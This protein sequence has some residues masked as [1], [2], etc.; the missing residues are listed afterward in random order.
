MTG[1]SER[2]PWTDEAVQILRNMQSA[3]R[4]AS[5]IAEAL[6]SA[7]K[8]FRRSVTRNAVLGKMHRLGLSEPKRPP[9]E[10]A[11]KAKPAAKPAPKPVR[12]KTVMRPMP[13]PVL[14]DP[15][16]FIDK[17][18]CFDL[19]T[20]G[21]GVHFQEISNGKCRWPL[22]DERDI[23]SFRFCGEACPQEARYCSGHTRLSVGSQHR[24]PFVPRKF[25]R[26]AA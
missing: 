18:G 21:N 7:A 1:H 24:A 4:S 9:P 17:N 5:E 15:G 22:G 16:S 12:E 6:R 13:K 26:L 19:P 8:G 10:E 2:S 25:G 3:G 20:D 23:E 11:L 14:P